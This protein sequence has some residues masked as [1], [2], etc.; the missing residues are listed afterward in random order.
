M[1]FFLLWSTCARN[2]VRMHSK[3]DPRRRETETSQGRCSTDVV[4]IIRIIPLFFGSEVLHAV[5]LVQQKVLDPLRP[6]P[7]QRVGE[8]VARDG[9][10]LFREREDL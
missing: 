10:E 5:E 7:L 6:F 3:N 2:R 1:R 8:E 9:R 4:I